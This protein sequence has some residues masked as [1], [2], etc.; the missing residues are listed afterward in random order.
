MAIWGPDFQDQARIRG[1]DRTRHTYRWHL[2]MRLIEP[3]IWQ[4]LWHATQGMDHNITD[5]IV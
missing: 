1:T 5:N 2:A 4:G 3:L